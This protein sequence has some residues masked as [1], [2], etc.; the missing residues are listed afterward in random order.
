LNGVAH[1][2]GS[3]MVPGVLAFFDHVLGQ[4]LY[5]SIYTLTSLVISLR[6]KEDLANLATRNNNLN[7]MGSKKLVYI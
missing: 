2:T 6:D 7:S 3:E 5:T 4:P 1:L